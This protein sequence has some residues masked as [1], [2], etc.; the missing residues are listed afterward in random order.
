MTGRCSRNPAADI[1]VETVLKKGAGVKHMA[2]VKAVE[3]PQLTKD[4][5]AYSGDRVTQ[6]A[7]QFMA[8]TF[9]RTTEMINAAWTEIEEKDAQ[10]ADSSRAYEDARSAHRATVAA[11][12]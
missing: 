6:L 2:R 1:D 10:M 11:G 5:A 9:V 7:L 4:I 3:I 8:L 12:P